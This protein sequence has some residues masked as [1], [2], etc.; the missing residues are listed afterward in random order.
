MDIALALGGGGVKGNAH[1]G[2]LRVLEREGFRIRAIAGTSAG[3]LWGSFYAAGF[4]PDEIEARVKQVEYSGFYHRNPDDLPAFLGLSGVSEW[5]EATIG[6]RTFEELKLPFAVTAVDI[7]T[8]KPLTLD[9]GRVADAVL[10]TIAVP[11]I[12]PPKR[13]NGRL[14]IDGGIVDPVPVALART[15]APEL[16][17]VAVVLSPILKEW[18]GADK[19]RLLTSLPFLSNYIARLRIAQAMNIFFRSIDIAGAMMTELR[20]KMDKPE[21]VIRP[22]LAQIGFLDD[23]DPVELIRI[24]EAAANDALPEIFRAVSWRGWLARKFSRWVPLP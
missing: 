15:L 11:G 10:A 9:S 21:V 3:G 13:L 6:D 7:D 4:T 20:L 16:P 14:L 19:P 8:A 5:L 2:V 18:E 12:F 17:V 1:V 23:I 24:G 22:K